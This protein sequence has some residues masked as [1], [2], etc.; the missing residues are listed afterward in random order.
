MART[1]VLFAFQLFAAAALAASSACTGLE[2]AAIG[3][4][5]SVA[6]SAV[7]IFDKGKARLV[8]RST[9]EETVAAARHAGEALSL[10]RREG[11]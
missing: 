11:S 9:F 8:D 7:T 4:G 1:P 5:A 6:S 10:R 3:A 2:P